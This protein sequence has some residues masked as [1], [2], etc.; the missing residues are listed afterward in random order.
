MHNPLTNLSPFLSRE[1]KGHAKTEKSQKIRAQINM[2]KNQCRS[3]NHKKK[4]SHKSN[5]MYPSLKRRPNQENNPCAILPFSKSQNSNEDN[6]CNML[7]LTLLKPEN[8]KLHNT[9]PP[10]SIQIKM[11]AHIQMHKDKYAINKHAN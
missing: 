1:D 2:S 11:N 9:T 10:Y 5:R 7:P 4:I 3:T 6:S 8:T